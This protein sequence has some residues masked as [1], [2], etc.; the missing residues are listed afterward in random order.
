MGMKKIKNAE[1][2]LKTGDRESRKIVLEILDDTLAKMDSYYVLK[3]MTSLNGKMLTIGERSWDLSKKRNVYLI[4]AGKA[5]NAMAKAFDEL[6]GEEL[7]DGIVIVKIVEETDNYDHVRMYQGGHPLPNE[8]SYQASLEVLK[9]VEEMNEDDL[10]IGL[11]SG[12]NSALL[13]CPMEGLTLEDEMQTRDVMLKSGA[14]VVEVNSV[15]RH[16]SAVNGGRLAQKIEKKGAEMVCILIMDALGYPAT[17]HPG[18]PR[19]FGFTQMAPD[20]TTLDD[21]RNAIK[22]YDVEDKLPPK[23]AEFFKNCTE[24]DETPKSLKKWTGYIIN[25]LPD[26]SIA[27]K[28]EAEKRGFRTMVLTN[29]LVG[30][31]CEAGNFLSSIAAEIQAS[32]QP[33]EP[34]CIIIATGEVS[35]KIPE[36]PKGS[37]GPGQEL[38]AGFA[39]ASRNL[40]RVCVAS[41]DTEGTDGPTD[42]AGGLTDSSTYQYAQNL[43]IDLYEAL[44]GHAVY[45]ALSTLNCEIITGNTGTNL[46]DLH[47][48][49]VPEKEV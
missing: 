21:A 20:A 11:M 49:Y 27:A 14:N 8:G 6:L 47:I 24:A 16:I 39:I 12:G 41:V 22:N 4:G 45:E 36:K 38:A 30:E 42:S 3:N 17:K 29:A 35:A 48:M 15:C 37:G 19:Q 43:G 40:E 18:V 1:E 25:T 26:V 33:I 34:P 2:L 46:C 28:E 44:R 32:G 23:V 31:S 9:M 10:V 7:A 5:A 13:S